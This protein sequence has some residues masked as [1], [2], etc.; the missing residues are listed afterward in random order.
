MSKMSELHAEL[1]R[2]DV[3]LND[4]QDGINELVS[5]KKEG[6]YFVALMSI[7]YHPDYEDHPLSIFARKA[8]N[9]ETM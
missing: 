7:A 4:L 3:L 2:F 9:G 1:Q 6:D 8:L 5:S